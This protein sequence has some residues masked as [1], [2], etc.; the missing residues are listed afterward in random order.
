VRYLGTEVSGTALYIFTEWVPGGSI[1]NLLEKFTKLKEKVV[2]N[3]TRQ[4]LVGLGY[5]HE[6]HVIHR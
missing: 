2:K 6:N 5:L 4:I 1:L 3:Y